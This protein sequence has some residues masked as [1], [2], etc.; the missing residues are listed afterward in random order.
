MTI[1]RM[2]REQMLKATSL[3]DWDRAMSIPDEDLD[4]SD[5]DIDQAVL[6]HPVQR[7]KP[8]KSIPQSA[9]DSHP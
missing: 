6:V 1:I 5:F 7:Q 2:T 8:S 4:T 3:S 9:H